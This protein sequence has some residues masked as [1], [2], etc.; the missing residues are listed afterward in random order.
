M[1]ERERERERELHNPLFLNS[2]AHLYLTE[3]FSSLCPSHHQNQLLRIPA[4]VERELMDRRCCRDTCIGRRREVVLSNKKM[5]RRPR[6][7]N[8]R[9]MISSGG[10]RLGSSI[11]MKVRRLQKLIPGGRGLQPNRLFLR[12]AD[13]ILHLRFQ[14]HV[15]QALSNLYIP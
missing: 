15:L 3:T 6:R 14:L 2:L 8:R 12:T 7:I 11:R 4:T 5:S 9:V 1:R 13:Y 10:H